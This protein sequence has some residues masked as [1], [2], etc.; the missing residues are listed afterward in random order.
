MWHLRFEMGRLG[1][2][3]FIVWGLRFG[4]SVDM[5]VFEGFPLTIRKALTALI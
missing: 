5:C 1:V 3:L 4:V 2:G